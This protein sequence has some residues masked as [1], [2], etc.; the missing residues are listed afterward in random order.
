MYPIT[1]CYAP[2]SRTTLLAERPS[3]TLLYAAPQ[4]G[5][6]V[7]AGRLRILSGRCASVK[8]CTPTMH[9]LPPRLMMDRVPLS[10]RYF[11]HVTRHR[12][13]DHIWFLS[14]AGEVNRNNE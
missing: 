5:P 12:H 11:G 3:W 2:W 13:S 7:R 8:P 14:E 9:E 10:R 6:H 1:I 4:G